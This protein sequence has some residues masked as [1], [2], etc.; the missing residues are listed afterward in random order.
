MCM[1]SCG[2]IYV[3]MHTFFCLLLSPLHLGMS[4]VEKN[5]SRLSCMYK[6]FEQRSAQAREIRLLLH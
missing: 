1:Q 2:R 6:K 4:T 3:V 5:I